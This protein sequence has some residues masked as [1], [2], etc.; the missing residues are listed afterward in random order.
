MQNYY[1]FKDAEGNEVIQVMQNKRGEQKGLKTILSERGRNI[2]GIKHVDML[3]MLAEEGDFKNQKI[4]L[5]ELLEDAE[6][7]VDFFPKV[8]GERVQLD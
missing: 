5:Q 1:K 2:R 8:H 3:A 7:E 6:M 4:W